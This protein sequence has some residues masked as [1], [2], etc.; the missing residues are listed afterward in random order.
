MTPDS[1]PLTNVFDLVS[2]Q[3]RNVISTAG[4]NLRFLSCEGSFE[5]TEY[6]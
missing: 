4:R 1:L 3:S 6:R 2:C 5:M